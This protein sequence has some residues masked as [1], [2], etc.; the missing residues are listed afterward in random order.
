MKIGDLSTGQAKL[1]K[2]WEK[3]HA[4]WESA[5]LHWHD[6]VSREFAENHLAAIEPAIAAVAQRMQI[7]AAT[8]GAAQQES[9]SNG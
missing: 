7:V 9:E 2:A 5:A 6:E 4:Q 1:R 3:L 8:F